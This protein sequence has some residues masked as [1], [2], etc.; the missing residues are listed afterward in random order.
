MNCSLSSCD[1]KCLDAANASF[2]L[3]HKCVP[4]SSQSHINVEILTSRGFWSLCPRMISLRSGVTVCDP[5]SGWLKLL[6]CKKLGLCFYVTFKLSC[7]SPALTTIYLDFNISSRTL[8]NY[9]YCGIDKYSL[10]DFFCRQPE[11]S[12][13]TRPPTHPLLLEKKALHN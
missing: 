2:S 4:L 5:G 3:L 8:L 6:L 9:T 12:G 10:A 13:G 7:I 11:L 1:R